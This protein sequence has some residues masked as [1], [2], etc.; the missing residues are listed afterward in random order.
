[1]SSPGGI[2]NDDITSQINPESIF[3][4]LQNLRKKYDA[5][6][7]YTVNLTAERDLMVKTYMYVCMCSCVYV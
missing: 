7:E 4:E 6:V 3:G 2:D 1:L 5:V